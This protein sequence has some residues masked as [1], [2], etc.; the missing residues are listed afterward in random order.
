[1]EKSLCPLYSDRKDRVR[2]AT[3]TTTKLGLFHGLS[4]SDQVATGDTSDEHFL[5]E[6]HRASGHGELRQTGDEGSRTG[7]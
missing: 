6:F 5:S 2:V 7:T 3:T 4:V 1:V